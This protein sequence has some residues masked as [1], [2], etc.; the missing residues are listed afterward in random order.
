M[1]EYPVDNAAE[2]QREIQKAML[3]N[4]ELSDDSS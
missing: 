4:Q 3:R 2:F 1:R